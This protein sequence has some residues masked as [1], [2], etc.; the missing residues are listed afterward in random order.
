[1]VNKIAA[2]FGKVVGN[3]LSREPFMLFLLMHDWISG[4]IWVAVSTTYS[5][6]K[7][8]NRD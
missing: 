4:L 8:L 3:C 6:V 1:M 5:M 7:V 2:I